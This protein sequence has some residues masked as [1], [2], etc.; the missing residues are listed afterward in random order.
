MKYRKHDIYLKN[1]NEIW[2]KKLSNETIMFLITKIKLYVDEM[3][4]K[5]SIASFLLVIPI[6]FACKIHENYYPLVFQ[7]NVNVLKIIFDNSY[8]SNDFDS[9]YP[10]YK[11]RS[12]SF[13]CIA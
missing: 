4:K 2:D 10:I 5:Y 13:T 11:I 3:R 1:Y 9:Q 12:I 6:D 7:K 8:D